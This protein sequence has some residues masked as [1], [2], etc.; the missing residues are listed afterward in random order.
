LKKA[1][2]VAIRTLSGIETHKLSERQAL[3]RAT[4]QLGTNDPN[5]IRYA[6]RLV[7]ETVRRKNL[8]DKFINSI[9][10]PTTTS[11]ITASVQ[12]F[13]RIYIYITRI[14]KNWVDIDF[15]EEHNGIW[16]LKKLEELKPEVIKS[17]FRIPF[18][19]N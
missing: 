4:R 14:A 15:E 6:Y 10:E 9:I 19:R 18:S 17:T 16:L 2:A 12:A 5:A 13:L 11:K 1:F 7:C 3:T 8:I